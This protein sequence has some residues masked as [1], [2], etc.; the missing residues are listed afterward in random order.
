MSTPNASKPTRMVDVAIIGAG[1]AGHNAY[2]Q[3]T[4]ATD[5]VVVINDGFWT[6]T[7]ATV[8]CMPSKL[9]IA[10][11]E[12]AHYAND[13]DEFGIEGSPIINGKQ[14][15]QRVQTERNRFAGFLQNSVEN[16]RDD[17][18]IHGH[19]T[20]T[21]EGYIA[22]AGEIVQAKHIIVGTGSAPYAPE[23][24]T[25]KLGD[26]LLNSDNVFEIP[27][28]PKSVAVIGAGAMGLEFS[29]ALH[30]LG[31]DVTLFNRSD[32]IGGIQDPEV[33]QVA[34]DCVLGDLKTELASTITDVAQTDSAQ[35]KQALL[36]YTDANGEQKTWQ[37]E[38]VLLAIG[39]RNTLHKMHIENVGVELDARNRPLNLDPVTGQA[40]NT[41]LYIVGDANTRMPLMHV[42][43]NEGYHAGQHIKKL[44]EQEKNSI[45]A[46]PESGTAANSVQAIK[47][48]GDCGAEMLCDD[49]INDD[50]NNNIHADKSVADTGKPYEG[51][52]ATPLAVV[53]SEPQIASVGQTL[54]QLEAANTPFVT[55]QV[56]FDNQG[57]S[58][59][60]G[61]NCG[62]LNIYAHAET[63]VILGACMV[64]PDAEYIAHILGLAI[65]NALTLD[66]MLASPYYHPTILEGLRTA[67]R[68]T[69]SKLK[70]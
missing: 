38:Y 36:H 45:G 43:S 16:W 4:K 47:A 67:L 64:G 65:T 59:V 29:L 27:D 28:L 15:M 11:A 51:K 49:S 68:R 34:L 63:G 56:S 52:P 12:R 25:E 60:M 55:G 37:G 54:P 24:W 7:C 70:S 50:I 53:F 39:R 23:G 57:R 62:V 19:A 42:A 22:A 20:F 69:R 5:S 26:R 32:R 9:L 8:G 46:A 41:N 13:S 30:R 48:S 1:T 10:A 2:H 33:N 58:R 14:V 6:T 18:K 35:D 40:A 3:V 44:I 31:V 61:V 21:P 17:Q 66:D